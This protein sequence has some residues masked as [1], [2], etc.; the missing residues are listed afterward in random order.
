MEEY[1]AWIFLQDKWPIALV[2]VTVIITIIT[3]RLSAAR[4][5]KKAEQD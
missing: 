1:N 4:K 2:V 5:M 3:V